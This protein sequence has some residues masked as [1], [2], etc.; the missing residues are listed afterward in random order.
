[1]SKIF[2]LTVVAELITASTI[3]GSAAPKSTPGHSMQQRGS[4]PGHPG[5]SGYAPGHLKK[6]KGPHDAHSYAHGHRR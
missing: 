4:V 5:A 2:A 1:M 6:K 3:A